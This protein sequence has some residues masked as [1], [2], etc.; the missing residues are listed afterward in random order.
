MWLHAIGSQRTRRIYRL[1]TENIKIDHSSERVFLHLYSCLIDK[2]Y[3]ITFYCERRGIV[4]KANNLVI[5]VR[6]CLV[7]CF[8][9]V[10]LDSI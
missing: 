8:L 4:A 3:V 2:V 9:V 1:M 7:L 6:A 5:V 10:S